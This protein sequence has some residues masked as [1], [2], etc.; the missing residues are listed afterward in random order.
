MASP[1]AHV[2]CVSAD[3]KLEKVLS[4]LSR[5]DFGAFRQSLKGEHVRAKY[6]GES[7]LLHYTVTSKDA[8]SV[9]RVLDL[10]ADVN[11]ATARGYTP[12]MVAVLHRYVLE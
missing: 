12:L 10:G 11:A 5:E 8:A 7:S 4:L 9:E 3:E 1:F 6:A 2:S